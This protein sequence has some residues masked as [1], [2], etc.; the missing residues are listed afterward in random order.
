MPNVPLVHARQG[1][2]HLAQQTPDLFIVGYRARGAF[3]PLASFRELLAQ[4]GFNRAGHVSPRMRIIRTKDIQMGGIPSRFQRWAGGGS[5]LRA[6]GALASGR[7]LG[8]M[9][10]R[11]ADWAC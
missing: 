4:E 7:P 9:A 2:V 10:P 11:C 3:E 6:G 8:E 5:R 1:G